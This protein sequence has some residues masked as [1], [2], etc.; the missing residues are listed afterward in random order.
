MIFFVNNIQNIEF[1]FSW[2]TVY[3]RFES[4]VAAVK[5]FCQFGSFYNRQFTLFF[6]A[7]LISGQIVYSAYTHENIHM[8]LH[9]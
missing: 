2:S 1:Q 3:K 6:I 8:L 9:L 4:V 7:P 5:Q